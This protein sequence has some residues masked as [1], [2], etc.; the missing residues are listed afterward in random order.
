MCIRDRIGATAYEIRL[1]LVGSEMCIRDSDESEQFQEDRNTRFT[2]A[3][4]VF[5]KRVIRC[6]LY[7][8]D[9]ADERSSVDLALDESEQFQEDRNTG[10]TVAVAV[11]DKRIIRVHR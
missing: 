6:L 8:S 4:A 7:T 9:A 2:V 1:S 10:F 5:D 3:V 11:F